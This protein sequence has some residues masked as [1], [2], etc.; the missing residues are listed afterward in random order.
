MKNFRGRGWTAMPRPNQQN[1]LARG[2]GCTACLGELILG[3]PFTA[4]KPVSQVLSHLTS[5]R[6][7]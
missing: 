7:I 3:W 4:P 6:P 2:R 5:E 1:S